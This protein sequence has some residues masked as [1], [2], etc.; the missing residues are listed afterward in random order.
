MLEPYSKQLLPCG[1]YV[2]QGYAF[3]CI[4]INFPAV[5]GEWVIVKLV[6]KVYVEE[7][8]PLTSVFSWD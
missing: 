4:G 8:L 7:S 2:K 3:G 5:H 6:Q 1:Y